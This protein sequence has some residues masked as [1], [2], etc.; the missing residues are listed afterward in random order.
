MKEPLKEQHTSDT[1]HWYLPDGTPAYSIIGKNGKE[2]NVTL[3]DARKNGYVP[4]VTS[5]IGLA[6]K[7]ALEIWKQD[8]LLMSCLTL[9]RIENEPE[10][11]YISRIRQDAKEQ[12]KN[13]AARGTL[14]HAYIQQGFEGHVSYGEAEYYYEQAKNVI[15]KECEPQEWLIEKPFGTK[16]Y[17]GKIDIHSGSY[18]IDIKTTEKDLSTVKLW[19]EHYQQ[20]G[21]Y[22]YGVSNYGLRNK[23]C[24]ILYV[25][26]K[27]G[28]VKLMW[29]TDEDIYRGLKC[30]VALLD[31]YYAKTGL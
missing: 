1:G 10:D 8:Q 27:S 5:I 28:D 17:G 7:P 16:R 2:R 23:K 20:L 4:S 24:G 6:A 13:A 18:I 29:A 19:D 31:Y 11:K 12:S 25:N 9:E 26:V 21:A 15:W 30:F 22:S 14:I 3:A